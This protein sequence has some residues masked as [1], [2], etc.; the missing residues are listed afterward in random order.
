MGSKRPAC[1]AETDGTSEAQADNV[2][3]GASGSCAS[4]ARC[5]RP[6][7]E[8][9]GRP[10]VAC[11]CSALPDTPLPLPA[12]LA[13]VL[14]LRHPK[15]RCQKHQSAWILERC[16]AGV[17]QH[18]TRR[19][20]P[21]SRAARQGGP[22][23]ACPALAPKPGLEGIYEDPASYLLI[24][25]AVGAKPLSEVLND[26]V[27]YLVFVDA[28]WRFARE[29][30]AASEPLSTLQCAVLT[31]PPG[32]RPVFVVRKPALL[33]GASAGTAEADVD[34]SPRQQEQHDDARWGF[35]TAEAVALAVDAV[36]TQRAGSGSIPDASEAWRVVARAVG[37]YAQIQLSHTAAPRHCPDRPG[38]IPRL[39]EGH[40]A[41]A[42]AAVAAATG[43]AAAPVASAEAA[44]TDGAIG[45][46]AEGARH[47][48]QNEHH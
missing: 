18:T 35:S 29:M 15:E 3:G 44:A 7:C 40:A 36:R 27:R 21:G 47:G 23:R 24:F 41:R 20:P 38:Y 34:G 4:G 22:D 10:L 46:G 19:L 32:I 16:L 26:S 39:Y 31:P 33:G 25:P 48:C 28:T 9:C 1:T 6:M 30:V 8:G 13:G 45:N 37:T 14:L 42:A 43:A 17:K 2:V 11:L 12:G 5:R